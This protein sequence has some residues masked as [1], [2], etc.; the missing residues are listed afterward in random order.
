MDAIVLC[1]GRGTRLESDVE[2]PLVRVC[3]DPM[4]DRVVGALQASR[5]D[6][7]HAAVSPHA[8]ATRERAAE[9]GL[10]LV[11]TPGAGYVEDLE[12][13]LSVV[14]RPAVTA[15]ADL[16][17]LAAEL[18]DELLEATAGASL[19]VYVPAALKRQLGVSADDTFERDGRNLAPAGLN[20]VGDDPDDL[21]VSH[22]ARL[23]VNVNRP[24]DLTVAEALCD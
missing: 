3:G 18:V 24:G 22:D 16:P 14:G 17:L 9:L 12:A 23:A 10:S 4:L 20:V 13:A 15:A 19:G 2:K 6:R 5:V 7:V 11:E 8:P 1:G 21:L